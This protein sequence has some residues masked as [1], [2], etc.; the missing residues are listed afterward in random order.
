[1]IKATKAIVDTV[2]HY[3]RPDVLRLMV[4]RNDTWSPA[5]AR[6]AA[7]RI[8]RAM[9]AAAADQH[10][11]DL[12][13]WWKSLPTPRCRELED[14]SLGVKAAARSTRGKAESRQKMNYAAG[15][16]RLVPARKLA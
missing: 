4:R 5:S 13:S 16:L 12:S 15:R 9:L 10:E 2:G 1:M 14:C 6:F 8:D 7:P 11:V 3:A